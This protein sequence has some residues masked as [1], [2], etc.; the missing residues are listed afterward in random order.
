MQLTQNYFYKTK[1]ECFRFLPTNNEDEARYSL[2]FVTPMTQATGVDGFMVSLS[3][4]FRDIRE[5]G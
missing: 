3:L 4:N 1:K 5:P 2:V